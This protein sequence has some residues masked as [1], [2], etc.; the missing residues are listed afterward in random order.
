MLL[1]LR[2]A[3]EKT[4]HRCQGDTLDSTVVYF[5]RS[6]SEHMHY[7]S[8]SRVRSMNTLF[9]LNFNER[10]IRVSQKV[11]EK[12]SRLRTQ[13]VL[14]PCILF[15]Y[16]LSD[17]SNCKIFFYNVR[18]LHLNIDDVSRDDNVK[19]APSIFVETVLCRHDN[20]GL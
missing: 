12:M 19:A 2:P 6:V 14:K 7:V 5:R 16:N 17:T 1:G 13:A 3:A 18:S 8:L 11:K 15:L 20:N 9:I 4:I 10:K